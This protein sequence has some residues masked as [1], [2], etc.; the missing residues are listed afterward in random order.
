MGKDAIMLWK[1]CTDEKINVFIESDT[2]TLQ[3]C[4]ATSIEVIKILNMY[5]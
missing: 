3:Q 5:V 1:G 2:I 4:L